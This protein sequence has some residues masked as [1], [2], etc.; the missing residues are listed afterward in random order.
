MREELWQPLVSAALV[1]SLNLSSECLFAEVPTQ[2]G[3][4]ADFVYAAHGRLTVFELKHAD[5]GQAATTLG[6]RDSRQIRHY[7]KSAHAVYVVTLCAPRTYS[8]SSD[9]RTVICEPLEAQIIPDGVG[10]ITFDRLS[11][12]ATILRPAAEL[13]PD[14]EHRDFVTAHLLARLT[15]AE[16]QLKGLRVAAA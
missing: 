13:Q 2:D 4:I 11:V 1:R 8:L 15:R 5:P 3:S 16:R 6:T 14:S 12:E 9:G 10:W 7:V